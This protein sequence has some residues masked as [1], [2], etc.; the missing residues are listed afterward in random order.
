MA[1]LFEVKN[2][3]YYIADYVKHVAK[4]KDTYKMLSVLP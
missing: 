4:R 1:I 2:Y 3:I